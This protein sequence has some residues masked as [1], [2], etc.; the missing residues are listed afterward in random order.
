MEWSRTSTEVLSSAFGFEARR[1]TFNVQDG[2]SHSVETRDMVH[3]NGT[4]ACILQDS[5]GRI[6]LEKL[7]RPIFEDFQFE[8]PAGGIEEGE[9]PEDAIRRELIEE[10]GAVV[11]DL[12]LHRTFQNSPGFSDQIT[13]IYCAKVENMVRHSR[14]GPEELGLELHWF[15]KSELLSLRDQFRDAKTLIGVD[16]WIHAKM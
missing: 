8:I 10:V 4:V 14:Q 12:E 13:Y 11:Y 9:S 5:L 2:N 15:D 6:V 16:L 7:Y 3:H 1:V